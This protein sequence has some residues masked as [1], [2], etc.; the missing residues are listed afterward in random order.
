LQEAIAHI[1]YLSIYKSIYYF[2]IFRS[3]YKIA[4]RYQSRVSDTIVQHRATLKRQYFWSTFFPAEVNSV[5]ELCGMI[6]GNFY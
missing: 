5:Y 1:F 2:M 3:T 4:S 6:H